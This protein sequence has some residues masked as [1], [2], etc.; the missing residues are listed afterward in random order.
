MANR[1]EHIRTRV[2]SCVSALCKLHVFVI[3]KNR[4]EES[5]AEMEW[6]G[7]SILS[8]FSSEE[9]EIFK[10]LH[11]CVR[12]VSGLR[13]GCPSDRLKKKGRKARN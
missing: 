5:R 4:E 6:F 9:L 3:V 11:G 7:R 2:E 8:S 12:V 13:Q 10:G 1:H